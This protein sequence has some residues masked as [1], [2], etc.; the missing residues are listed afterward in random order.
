MYAIRHKT[1]QQ[2][3]PGDLLCATKE[4]KMSETI[5]PAAAP[6]DRLATVDLLA[7][8]GKFLR[9]RVADG[10]ASPATIRTYHSQAS[11]FVDWC[12]EK[13]VN[14]ASA[15]EDDVIAYRK[16]LVG[17]GYRRSTIALKLAV[18]RRLYEAAAWRGLRQDNPAA[19][20][21]APRERTS[22][23]ERVKFLP[24]EGLKRLLTAPQG[25]SAKAIRDRAILFL[26]GV[27]GLR[28]AEVADLQIGDVSMSQG[29]VIVTG[30]GSKVR[31]VYLTEATGSVLSE[32][33][34]ARGELAQRHVGAAFVVVGPNGTGTAIST[35]AIR[36]LVDGY[37]DDLGL[38]REGVSC[39]SLRRSA[40]TW[41]RAGGAS[42]DAIAGMLGH[43]NVTTSQAYA[44]IVEKMTEN[45]ARYLEAVLRT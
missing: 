10:D 8:F 40:A 20:V 9:L 7:D 21:K 1:K 4:V 32:W 43:A 14:P 42:L 44:K 34:G 45:P 24:L 23:D 28:V 35:C 26:M 27:H 36:Y 38:K 30:K 2:H 11:Q 13:G 5:L 31:T 15:V 22:S 3:H 39:H 12:R 6:S 29:I 16:F 18:V 37:L 17:A 41:A 33:L 25:D 19:G